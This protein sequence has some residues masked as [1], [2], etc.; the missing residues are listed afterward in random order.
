MAKKKSNDKGKGGGPDSRA[1]VE[2]R[3]ADGG[4]GER[5]KR[6]S[7]GATPKV[8]KRDAGERDPKGGGLH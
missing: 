6:S 2:R 8:S 5:D 3:K 7:A 4:G 1:R